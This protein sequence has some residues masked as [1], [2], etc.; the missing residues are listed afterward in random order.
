MT[1]ASLTASL[2]GVVCKCRLHMYVC[3]EGHMRGDSAGLVFRQKVWPVTPSAVR[4]PTSRSEGAPTRCKVRAI[5][6]QCYWDC[7]LCMTAV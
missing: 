4:L 7:R 6:G 2:L 5:Y 3:Q 1:T